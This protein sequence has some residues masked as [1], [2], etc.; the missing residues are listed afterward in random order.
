M[1]ILYGFR[2]PLLRLAPQQ[3]APGRPA[4]ERPG[5]QEPSLPRTVTHCPV[6]T[7]FP[8]TSPS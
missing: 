8:K 7:I 4:P 5:G 3:P 2:P 6:K 1:M